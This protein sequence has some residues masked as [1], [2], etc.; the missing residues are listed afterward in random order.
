MYLKTMKQS[1]KKVQIVD[2]PSGELIISSPQVTNRICECGGMIM[3][4]G[5]CILE[6]KHADYITLYTCLD[7]HQDYQ[8]YHKKQ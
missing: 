6:E 5:D 8:V 7:C 4:V 1:S 2:T 3:E